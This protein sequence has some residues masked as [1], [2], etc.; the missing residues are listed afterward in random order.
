MKELKKTNNKKRK[1]ISNNVFHLHADKCDCCRT[2]IEELTPFR[3]DGDQSEGYSNRPLLVEKYRSEMPRNESVETIYDEFFGDC[4]TEEECLKADYLMREKYGNEE[5]LGIQLE[6]QQIRATINSWECKTCSLLN[7]EQY[8]K[9]IERAQLAHDD[10]LT[11]VNDG[12]GSSKKRKPRLLII[13]TP[14]FY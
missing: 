1:T 7:D 5:A 9:A 13:N 2:P 3:T 14:V 11:K 4:G 10:E 12:A 8:H 6:V